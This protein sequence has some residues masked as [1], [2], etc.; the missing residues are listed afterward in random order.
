DPSSAGVNELI[1]PAIALP[2]GLAQLA[3]THNYNTE[4]GYDG[5]VLEIKIGSGA[6][7]DILTAGGSFAS[8]EYNQTL[9]PSG[10]NPMAGRRAWSGTSGGF[11]TTVVNLPSAAS[12]QNVQ[13]R[14]RCGAD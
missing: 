6:F 8:G 1:S 7:T 11:V 14:W 3:F 10:A 4:S 5:G 13:F 9:S 12:G 2:T